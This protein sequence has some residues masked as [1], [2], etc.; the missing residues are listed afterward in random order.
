MSLW[1][2]LRWFLDLVVLSAAFWA[3]ASARF[4]WDIPEPML[5]RF[6]V[7]WPYVLALQYFVLMAFGVPRFSWRYVGLPE[8]KQIFYAASTAAGVLL[9]VR[10]AA[11]GLKPAYPGSEVAIVPLGVI[12]INLPLVLL[13]VVGA[14]VA[15]RMLAERIQGAAAVQLREARTRVPEAQLRRELEQRYFGWHLPG[16]ALTALSFA[17]VTPRERALGLRYRLTVPQASRR[18]GDGFA[19]RAV[20][21]PARLG[22]G[23]AQLATRQLPLQVGPLG[24]VRVALEVHLPPGHELRSLPPPLAR[25]T[26]V[27]RLSFAAERRPHGARIMLE[28]HVPFR[29][30]S[31]AD[32]AAFAT[33]AAEVDRAEAQVLTFRKR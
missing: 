2:T 6:L 5:W 13:G 17:G 8:A 12:L 10:L 9:L 20:L 4:D 31:P 21:F 16:A 7:T 11:M 3:A 26:A 30:V 22:R 27:G 28:L 1:R 23:H 18:E 24:P 29:V 15:R 33:F 19:V 32:Y 25:T 14:R